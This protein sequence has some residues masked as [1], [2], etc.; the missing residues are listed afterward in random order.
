MRSS[1]VTLLIPAMNFTCNLT[2]AGFTVAGTILNKVPHS[3]L[4]IWRKNRSQDFA[5]YKAGNIIVNTAA[6]GGICAPI[7]NITY[8]CVLFQ[9]SRLSVQPGDILGLQ[10]P[11]NNH[12]ILFTLNGGPVNFIHEGA[13]QLNSTITL[14]HNES[15]SIVKQLPQI[16]FNF[17]SG[18]LLVRMM[19]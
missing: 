6:G 12:E 14:S 1:T 11:N 10:L 19:S 13:Y 9:V 5:Y 4:Q 17:T 3:H 7:V 18:K 2:I 16:T 8:W 15:D